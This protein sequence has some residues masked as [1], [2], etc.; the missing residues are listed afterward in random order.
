MRM[1]LEAVAVELRAL[2]WEVVDLHPRWGYGDDV[3]GYLWATTHNEENVDFNLRLDDDATGFIGSK[4][5]GGYSKSVPFTKQMLGTFSVLVKHGFT[6]EPT[7]NELERISHEDALA[8]AERSVID[9]A[10]FMSEYGTWQDN[11]FGTH[12]LVLLNRFQEL[13]SALLAWR[14]LGGQTTDEQ[15]DAIAMFY[16]K[17]TGL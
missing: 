4:N 2:G 16:G 3:P 5:G 6:I 17:G 8:I 9:S 13:Q 12:A 7:E 10:A 15:Q 14:A 1:N 11:G